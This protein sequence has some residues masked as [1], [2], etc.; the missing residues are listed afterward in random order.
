[1]QWLQ[2]E[3]ENESSTIKGVKYFHINLQ[4][5]KLGKAEFQNVINSK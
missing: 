5:I 2:G 3:C 4:G 1:M